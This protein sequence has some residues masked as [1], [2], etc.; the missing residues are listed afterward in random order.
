MFQIGRRLHGGLP[1]NRPVHRKERD[2]I[3]QIRPMRG[4]LGQAVQA[5]R[6][7]EF[8]QGSADLAE[9]PELSSQKRE[10]GVS[11][12]AKPLHRV[13]R[14]HA[15]KIRSKRAQVIHNPGAAFAFIPSIQ[16]HEPH[17]SG[18]ETAQKREQVLTMKRVH[19]FFLSGYRCG[20]R[21]HRPHPNPSREGTREVPPCRCYGLR[22]QA[23]VKTPAR[24]AAPRH[25][26]LG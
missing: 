8:G 15:T 13:T 4:L 25:R 22:T 14:R 1:L 19:V 23:P 16:L 7:R 11:F 10:R 3:E 12:G 20:R 24:G 21:P 17:G 5:R 26:R 6:R 2:Q 9:R 18:R